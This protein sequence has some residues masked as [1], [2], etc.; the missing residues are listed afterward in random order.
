MDSEGNIY[1]TTAWGGG[2][3]C[4]YGCGTVFELKR[5]ASGWQEKILYRFHGSSNNPA[6]GI[7]FDRAGNIYGTT[8]G[9]RNDCNQGNVF[10]LTPNSQGG[11]TETVLYSFDCANS[12]YNPQSD[13]V[14]DEQGDLFGTAQTSVFELI[15]KGGGKWKEVTVHDFKGQPDGQQTTSAVAIDSSGNLWGTTQAGGT[16]RCGYQDLRGCGIVYK[17]APENGGKWS[18]TAVYEFAR[19]SGNAVN[20]SNAFLMKTP[21][22]FLATSSGGGDGS[23]AVFE[24]TQSGKKWTQQVLYRFLGYPDGAYPIGQLKTNS[25]GGLLGVT[26]DGGKSDLGTIFEIEPSNGNAWKE[27]ILHHFSGGGDGA[28]PIAGV[29]SDS[30]GHFYGT[31]TTGGTGTAC[32]AG[33]GT[34]YEITPTVQ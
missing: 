5:T 9:T 27:K 4:N 26:Y 12:G 16:K 21:E 31:T 22:D 18:E 11:W 19:G 33:C 15:P 17:F 24:L 6:A 28:Y 25:T 3:G 8:L 23:G 34:V 14:F 13:L 30:K 2:N 29:I 7:I 10:E 32:N 1:G 20:P